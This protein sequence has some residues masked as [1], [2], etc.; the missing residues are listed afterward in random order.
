MAEIQ[1][2]VEAYRQGV[3]SR[4]EFIRRVIMVAGGLA[5]A[6]PYLSPLGI[7]EAEAAQVDPNDPSL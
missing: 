5:A 4:R 7:Q 2:L 1:K 3:L 6:L